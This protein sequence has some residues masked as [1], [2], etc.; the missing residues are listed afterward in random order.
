MNAL[1][2][3]VEDDTNTLKLISHN[4]TARGY[5]IFAADSLS[6]TIPI[7]ERVKPDLIVLDPNLKDAGEDDV[8]AEIRSNPHFQGIPMI[9]IT[10]SQKAIS[11]LQEHPLTNVLAIFLKPFDITDF[12]TTLGNSPS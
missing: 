3:I 6:A 2:L 4:L 1:I 5:T 12:V 10:G 8:I 7:L 9:I 11:D